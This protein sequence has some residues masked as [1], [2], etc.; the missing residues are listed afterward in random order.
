MDVPAEGMVAGLVADAAGQPQRVWES[1]GTFVLYPTPS[2]DLDH[3]R[4]QTKRAGL[5]MAGEMHVLC[6]E[7]IQ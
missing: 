3:T 6:P 1:R 7:R 5:P 2:Y 4:A